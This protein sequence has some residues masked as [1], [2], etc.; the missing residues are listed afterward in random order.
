MFEQYYA[1][2]HQGSMLI[3]AS[4]NEMLD[5][6]ERYPDAVFRGFKSRKAAEQYVSHMALRRQY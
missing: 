4:K 3:A 5:L 1:A 2:M 6:R